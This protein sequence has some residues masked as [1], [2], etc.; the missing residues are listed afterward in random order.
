MIMVIVVMITKMLTM[1]MMKIIMKK[2]NN[3]NYDY[4]NNSTDGVCTAF[5]DG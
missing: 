1:I 2:Y 3:V 4:V 5:E